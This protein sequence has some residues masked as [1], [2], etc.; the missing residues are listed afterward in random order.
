MNSKNLQDQHNMSYN[1][2]QVNISKT[3][4]QKQSSLNTAQNIS[5]DGSGVI[6]IGQNQPS[7]R[8]LENNQNSNNFTLR[9]HSSQNSGGNGNYSQQPQVVMNSS[10]VV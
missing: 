4:D 9:S 5:G 2:N 7:K 8:S 10:G 1:Q 3:T 6:I